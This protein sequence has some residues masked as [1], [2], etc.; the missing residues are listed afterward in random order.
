MAVVISEGLPVRIWVNGELTYNETVTPNVNSEIFHQRFTNYDEIRMQIQDADLS[1]NYVLL[2]NDKYE[3]TLQSLNFVRVD[4]VLT[5][6]FTAALYDLNETYIQL[7]I[8][9]LDAS[10]ESDVLEIGRTE[11]GDPTSGGEISDQ[12]TETGTAYDPWYTVA[13]YWLYTD[14]GVS[15]QRS[16]AVKTQG[17]LVGSSGTTTLELH[18]QIMGTFLGPPSH[19]VDQEDIMNIHFEFY[20]GGILQGEFVYLN[21]FADK[22]VSFGDTY[23]HI[24][25][26]FNHA[27]NYDQIQIWAEFNGTPVDVDRLFLEIF[28]LKVNDAVLTVGAT[29]GRSDLIHITDLAEEDTL[30]KYKDRR[31]FA[32]LFYDDDSLY[33]TVRVPGRF[34]HGRPTKAQSEIDLEDK[35]IVT[36]TSVSKQTLLEIDH[37]PYYFHDMIN[38]FLAHSSGSLNL[39]GVDWISRDSYELVTD[40]LPNDYPLRPA[41]TYLTRKNYNK[42]NIS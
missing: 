33:F 19:P 32:G 6:Y 22:D 15:F 5:A 3:N 8:S 24:V 20:S 25:K 36:G 39:K 11:E 4:K 26:S 23:Y 29:I 13:T 12:L 42:R 34:Y 21:K 31:S 40:E 28:Y 14:I 41:T 18:A 35:N 17:V 10:S 27:F 9:E 16:T 2:I 37:V 38:L 30:M 7:K 1:K